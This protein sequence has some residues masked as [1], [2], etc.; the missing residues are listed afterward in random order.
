[1]KRS[2]RYAPL[3]RGGRHRRSLAR[4]LI[5]E[6]LAEA[7]GPA[8]DDLPVADAIDAELSECHPLSGRGHAEVLARVRSLSGAP[9]RDQVALR[10]DELDARASVREP[11]S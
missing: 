10:Q 9:V 8:L 2:S 7:L 5:G 4:Q 6:A 3:P 1:M 11:G